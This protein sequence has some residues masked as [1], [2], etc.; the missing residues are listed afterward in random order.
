M[1]SR[2]ERET[3][4][5]LFGLLFDCVVSLLDILPY[6]VHE[7]SEAIFE[8][9]HFLT[10]K[11]NRNEGEVPDWRLHPYQRECR[12]YYKDLLLT[13]KII[14]N[15]FCFILLVIVVGWNFHTIGY[16]KYTNFF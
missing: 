12:Y 11:V 7:I 15:V 16:P 10:L 4:L 3:F 5:I 1:E 2:S 14:A 6:K 13:I 9:F 8:F